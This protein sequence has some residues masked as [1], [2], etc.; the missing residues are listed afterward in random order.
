MGGREGGRGVRDDAIGI[1]K[2]IYIQHVLS[3]VEFI[4]YVYMHAGILRSKVE[5]L[6]HAVEQEHGN[7]FPPTCEQVSLYSSQDQQ[8]PH[9]HHG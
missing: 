5:S 8:E 9:P 1:H 3:S 6:R 7:L 4:Y 2:H